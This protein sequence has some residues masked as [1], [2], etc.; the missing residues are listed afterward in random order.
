[1]ETSLILNE[2]D[3]YESIKN[4]S[5]THHRSI[6]RE[7]IASFKDDSSIRLMFS[8]KITEK[9]LDIEDERAY[10][11]RIYQSNYETEW[12]EWLLLRADE[13][14]AVMQ[15]EL[16]RF[17]YYWKIC[18]NGQNKEDLN[19]EQAKEFPIENIM[20]T[21]Y[22]RRCAGRMSY[23]CPFHSDTNPSFMVYE[24]ENRFYCFSCGKFGDS[25]QLFMD[26]NNKTFIEAVKALQ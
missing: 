18:K 8:R 4:G 26:L 7:W 14:I 25:L 24:K 20:Q 23:H 16:K 6:L 10:K 1:M 13:R 21:K 3:Y 11:N 9:E 17:I 12:K 2:N 19:I 15:K 22:V 5:L